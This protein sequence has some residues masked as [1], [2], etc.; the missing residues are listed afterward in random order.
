[1]CDQYQNLVYWPICVLIFV[2]LVD[3]VLHDW[4]MVICIYKGYNKTMSNGLPTE[5]SQLFDCLE[6][7]NEQNGI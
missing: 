2:R 4:A 1:M 7:D 5:A 3:K 6:L